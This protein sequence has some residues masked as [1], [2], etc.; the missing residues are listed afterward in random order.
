[1]E[2]ETSAIA[3]KLQNYVDV[4]SAQYQVHQKE[5]PGIFKN[6]LLISLMGMA[7]VLTEVTLVLVRWTKKLED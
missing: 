5:E 2:S 3:R 1:M 4:E 6:L 7:V